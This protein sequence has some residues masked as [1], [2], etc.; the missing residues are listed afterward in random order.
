MAKYVGANRNFGYL[1]RV[2]REVKTNENW[3]MAELLK[4]LQDNIRPGGTNYIFFK[5]IHFY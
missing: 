4:K 1:A 5:N 2:N 3:Y